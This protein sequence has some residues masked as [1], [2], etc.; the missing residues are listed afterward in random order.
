MSEHQTLKFKRLCQNA[1]VP[2]RGSDGAAG[3]DLYSV[4]TVAIPPHS[5]A[6]IKTGLSVKIPDGHYGRIASRSGLAQRESADVC[7]G[8]VDQD[9]RGEVGVLI[10]NADPL[11]CLLLRAGE[12]VAQLI[13]E[14]CSILPLEEVE[15]LDVTS[16]NNG[17]FGSTGMN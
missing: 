11:R 3:Y 7:A 4:E 14:K 9:Y 15:D 12:R 5:R 16:R 2:T 8:V 10:H 17:G 13:L 6:L 1:K